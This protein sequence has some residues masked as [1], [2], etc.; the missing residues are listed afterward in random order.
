MTFISSEEANEMIWECLRYVYG[1]M[2]LD[3]QWAI[4]LNALM[5]EQH[6]IP[7][8]YYNENMPTFHTTLDI[9]H[10]DVDEALIQTLVEEIKRGNSRVLEAWVYKFRPD[11]DTRADGMLWWDMWASLDSLLEEENFLEM[12]KENLGLTICLK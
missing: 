9:Y 12:L 8:Q 3:E 10:G 4:R 7:F 2:C 11:L 1:E 5:E 6:I